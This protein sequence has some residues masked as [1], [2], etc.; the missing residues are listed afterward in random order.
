MRSFKRT[1][2]ILAIS[3]A[4][5]YLLACVLLFLTQRSFLYFPTPAAPEGIS[6]VSIESEGEIL[7]IITRPADNPDA[8]ILFGGNADDVSAYLGSFAAALP[9]QNLFLVNYRGY[10]GS[11]GTPSESALFTDAVAVY[12]HV[13]ARSRSVSVVGRS[14]GSGVAV[15]LASVRDVDKLILITPYDSIENV[16]KKHFPIFP[17]GLLLR[18][19]FDSASRVQDVSAR[20]LILIAEDDRTIPRE[21]TLA[22]ARKFRSDHIVVKTLPGTTHNS[23]GAGTEYFEVIREFLDANPQ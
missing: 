1:V 12:D 15:H 22:L 11:S 7:R 2:L 17:I 9:E 13:K 20:T 23:I 18:D 14:L 10:G 16:A 21:N 8:I 3:I 19:K 4:T 5:L 6:S